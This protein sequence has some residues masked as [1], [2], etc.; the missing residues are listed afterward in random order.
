LENPTKLLDSLIFSN[1]LLQH[2]VVSTGAGALQ[3]FTC[4]VVNFFNAT[5]N[6]GYETETL[7]RDMACFESDEE[8]IRNPN[9]VSISVC[10]CKCRVLAHS[11]TMMSVSNAL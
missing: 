8:S 1:N 3:L 10:A 6:L 2:I 11:N 5:P 9:D 7:M 4:H